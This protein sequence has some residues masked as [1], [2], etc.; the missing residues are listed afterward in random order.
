M[1]SSQI[2]TAAEHKSKTTQSCK[3]FDKQTVHDDR[4]AP[5]YIG[6]TAALSAQ[7]TSWNA[8]LSYRFLDLDQLFMQMGQNR[9][10]D[11]KHLGN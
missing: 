5:A 6:A 1:C 9:R 8:E 2:L 7:D 10:E 11:R 4:D 3:S